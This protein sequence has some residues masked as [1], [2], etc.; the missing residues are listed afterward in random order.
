MELLAQLAALPSTTHQSLGYFNAAFDLPV[1]TAYACALERWM[2]SCRKTVIPIFLSRLRNRNVNGDTEESTAG[3]VV[4]SRN[5]GE[6]VSHDQGLLNLDNNQDT[7]SRKNRNVDLDRAVLCIERIEGIL[8]KTSNWLESS[9]QPKILVRVTG[10]PH[11]S[12]SKIYP[13]SGGREPNS[14]PERPRMPVNLSPFANVRSW[15]QGFNIETATTHITPNNN[16]ITY[17]IRDKLYEV[18]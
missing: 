17:T 4:N 11:T 8:E 10:E 1:L 15:Q 9:K 7:Y 18:R 6:A 3:S 12:P 13:M 5:P 16:N 2:G 14:R